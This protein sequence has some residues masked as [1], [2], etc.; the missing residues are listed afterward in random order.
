[1]VSGGTAGVAS[2]AFTY[3]IDTAK[4]LVQGLPLS[5]PRS[6]RTARAVLAANLREEGSYS[7]LFRGFGATMARAFMNRA[8]V[9]SVF[10]VC[11][12]GMDKH[13]APR[14]DEA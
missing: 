11:V 2:W 7:F 5:T 3:P 8:V 10:E 6:A 1:M 4:S 12:S 9:F 14:H 13:A